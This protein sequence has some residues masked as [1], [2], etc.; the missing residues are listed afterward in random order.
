LHEVLKEEGRTF[1]ELAKQIPGL[2]KSHLARWKKGQWD[3]IP[4][5][6]EVILS[7]TKDTDR[8]TEL[9][10]AYIMDQTPIEYR[11]TIQVNAGPQARAEAGSLKGYP[12]RLLQKLHVIGEAYPLD[13]EFQR[14]VDAM[15]AWAVGML[16]GSA[17]KRSTGKRKKKV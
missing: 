9:I 3:T 17:L 10:I 6:V 15:S 13:Q 5:L 4:Q 12:P 16:A 1:T 14:S 8:R 7:A 2:Q 11:G